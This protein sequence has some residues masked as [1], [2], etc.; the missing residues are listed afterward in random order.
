MQIVRLV[1]EGSIM[2]FHVREAVHRDAALLQPQFVHRLLLARKLPAQVL[3]VVHR[4]VAR[5]WD[6]K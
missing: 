2:E 5:A 6:P 1:T 4:A 3:L